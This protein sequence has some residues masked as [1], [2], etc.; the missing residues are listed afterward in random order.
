MDAALDEFASRGFAGAR[1]DRIAAVAHLNKAMLYYHFG[2]KERL[3][4]ATIQRTIGLLADR[5]EAVAAAPGAPVDKL[6]TFVDTFIRLGLSQP[7]IAPLMLREIA[8]G[9]AHIDAD[10]IHL[11]L[12]VVDA[13]GSIVREG[14]RSGEFRDVDPLM[15]YLTTVWPIMVYLASGRIRQA[16]ISQTD[17]AAT[18]FS[19][20][21]FTQHMQDVSLRTLAAAPAGGRARRATPRH[22]EQ[23]P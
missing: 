14:Q 17:A 4:R 2:S 5:M 7:R 19:F 8:E 15:V 11:M 3:Y 10:T 12:R 16:V 23:E 22:S 9:A 1:V 20:D 6:R 21:A 18:T 13:M